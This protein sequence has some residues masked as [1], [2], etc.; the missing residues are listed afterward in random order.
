M[1][2]YKKFAS[3]DADALIKVRLR[4]DLHNLGLE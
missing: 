2:I 3:T 1:H 4:L